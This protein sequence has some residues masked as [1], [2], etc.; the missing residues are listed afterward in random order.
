MT[1]HNIWP[2][3]TYDDPIAARAWLA[4]LGFAEGILVKDDNDPTSV[5]HSEMYWP[6]GGR[7]MISSRSRDSKFATAPGAQG[8]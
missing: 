7:V 5:E 4:S 3:F 2:G 6:E 8:V 1:D